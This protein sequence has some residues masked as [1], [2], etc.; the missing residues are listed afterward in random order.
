MKGKIFAAVCAALLMTSGGGAAAQ[1]MKIWDDLSGGRR[2]SELTVSLPE[3][4]QSGRTAVIVCPG[5][6]YCYLGMEREGRAVARWLNSEGVAAF[7]LRYRV[8]MYGNH[9]PA[10][11][12]D[13]QRAVQIV[14]EHAGEWGVDPA[15]VGVMGFS[16]GGHLA[17]TLGTY[18]DRDWLAACGVEC[19]VPLRPDFVAM[20]YP[21]VTMR[22]DLAHRKSRRNLLTRS[23]TEEDEAMMSLEENVR[24]DMPP[25]FLMCC[26]DDAT[27]DC[28]NS[29]RYAEALAKAGVEHEFLFMERGDHGFGADTR[30]GR[31]A[32]VEEW[33]R[34]FAQWLRRVTSDQQNK[35]AEQ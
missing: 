11:I 13:L 4:P 30:H 3:A 5:G 34:R 14:R 6:S 24:P 23:R 29:Q 18:F 35:F 12:E 1:T 9:H 7:V 21:V 20:M 2:R 25:V 8:G 17:G 10:M 22:D 33:T 31:A 16:A 32:V 27:V 26:R 19:S 15:K 28:R